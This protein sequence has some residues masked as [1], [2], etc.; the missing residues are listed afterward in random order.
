[1]K[2]RLIACATLI[3]LL[4]ACTPTLDWREVRPEGSGMTLLLPC[5]PES[6]ARQVSLAQRQVRL[7]LVAC[8][9]GASTWALAFADMADPTAVGPALREL[10]A[11]AAGNLGAAGPRT[12]DLKVVGATPNALSQRIEV[13]GRLPDGRAVTAQ[14]AVFARGTRVFQATVLGAMPDA[15][16]L[17][18]FFDSLRAE[19]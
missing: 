1:M 3:G 18:T 8:A 19:P 16:A 7:V 2:P 10:A 17:E 6:H 15:Q 4:T 12:L 11:S 9:A 13:R 5:K 14:L